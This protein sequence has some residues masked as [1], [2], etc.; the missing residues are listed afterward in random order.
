MGATHRFIADPNEPSEVLEWFRALS[1]APTEILSDRGLVLSFPAHGP[2]SYR[3]NG[4]IDPAGS[5]VVTLFLPRIRRGQLW[6]V[7][8]VHFLSTPLRQQFPGLYKVSSTFGKWL[9]Q[10]ECVYSNKRSEN[11]LGYYLE[12]SVK[13]HDS[14]VFAF[15]SALSALHN[16]RYFVADGD[17]EARLDSICKTLRL[18]GVDCS[19]V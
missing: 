5:P 11:S 7:G 16:G 3:A 18:R 2:L 17:N 4:S 6:T 10:L 15:G 13:D 1:E 12:G 19:A 9:S 14:P 8:E